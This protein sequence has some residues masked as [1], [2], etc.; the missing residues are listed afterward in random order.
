MENSWTMIGKD[1]SLMMEN[2]FHHL[3]KLFIT[4]NK[5]THQLTML[6]KLLGQLF[7]KLENERDNDNK[8]KNGNAIYFV[9]RILE[10]RF[11]KANYIAARTI[12]SYYEKYVEGKENRSGEPSSELKDLMA[13]Y[14]G[15]ENFLGFENEQKSSIVK[16]TPI[17]SILIG[18]LVIVS[19]ILYY[20]GVFTTVKCLVW[21][22][23]HYEKVDC[24]GKLPNPILKDINIDMFK[25]V[26][27]TA[28]STFFVNGHPVIWYGKSK[29][30]N[31]EYFNSAG[32]HPVTLKPLK[33]ITRYIIEKY[34]MKKDSLSSTS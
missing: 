32:L 11:G 13:Q 6:K 25:K 30:G 9:E 27:V 31:L 29:E 24:D 17:W 26:M 20:N 1:Y 15:Y 3:S 22:E 2:I 12:K 23:N 16:S 5:L 28:D 34:I 21:N 8:S 7:D 14:L 19:S 33:P 10:E 18:M 4:L